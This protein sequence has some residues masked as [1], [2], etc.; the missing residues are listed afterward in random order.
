MVIAEIY[1][2]ISRTIWGALLSGLIVLLEAGY[3]APLAF[4]SFLSS[5]YFLLPSKLNLSAYF[6]HF[7]VVSWVF[8]V[9]FAQNYYLS[10]QLGLAMS[11]VTCIGMYG[12]LRIQNVV[13]PWFSQSSR[14]S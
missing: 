7:Y 4:T 3:K 10:W 13:S 12:A 5:D 9:T 2:T 6:I 8:Q 11:V 1:D 14:I